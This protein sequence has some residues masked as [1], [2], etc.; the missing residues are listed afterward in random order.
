M[1]TY[2]EKILNILILIIGIICSFI[3]C[4]HVFLT[5]CTA[6]MVSLFD[7][8][9]LIFLL[10]SI[11][12]LIIFWFIFI[13]KIKSINKFLLLILLLLFQICYIKFSV[14]I[15][16]V[17]QIIEVEHSIDSGNIYSSVQE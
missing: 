10:L 8:Q 9:I 13:I 15:P 17:N 7:Y 12:L 16:S 3:L 4:F 14:Y 11:I 6:I 5:T 2:I 1:N